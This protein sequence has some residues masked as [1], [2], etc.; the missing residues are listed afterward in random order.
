MCA[1]KSKRITCILLALTAFAVCAVIA[2]YATGMPVV[3]GFLGD[4]AVMFLIYFFC[5]ALRDNRPVPLAVAVLLFAVSIEVLQYFRW[6]IAG[7]GH[8]RV[9]RIVL[10]S[11]FDPFDLLA[12][13]IGAV[14]AC[15]IDILLVRKKI[16]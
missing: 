11:V 1:F 10:G 16:D 14:L 7:L 13:L 8:C 4:I 2:I 12:Y 3:R 5:Q 9:A 6:L 15:T